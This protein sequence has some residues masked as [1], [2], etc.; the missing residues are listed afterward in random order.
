MS[1]SV[2]TKN[3]FL[4]ITLRKHSDYIVI[5]DEAG[6]QVAH[7]CANVQGSSGNDRIRVSIRADQRYRIHR[8]KAEE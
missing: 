3:G 6:E 8:G 1:P 5:L 7:I 4:T 2:E